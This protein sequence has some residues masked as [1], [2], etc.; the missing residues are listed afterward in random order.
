[1]AYQHQLKVHNNLTKQLEP[2]VPI[3]PQQVRMYVC[4][5][6]VYDYCHIGHARVLVVFDIISRYLRHIYGAGKVTYVRNITDIDDKII[7]RANDNGEDF[8]V[9]TGRFIEAMH[10]DADA[11]GVAPPDQEPRA[12]LFMAEIIAMIGQLIANG[13]AYAAAN[14]DV[15]Y[16]VSKFDGYGRLSGKNP[17]DLRAG[18]RV[19]VDEAKDDP[20]DFVL[21]KAA[22]PDEPSWDSPWG[23]GRPGWHIEC[24]VMST[25]ALGEHFDIHGGGLDLQFPHHE[26]EI[27]QSEGACG[28]KFVNYWLHNGFV[29]VDNEKMSK[30]LGNFFTIREVM[31]K[32]D[33]EVIRYFILS[34]HYRSPLNYSDQHLDNAKAALTSLYNALRGIEADAPAMD[35]SDYARRFYAAM[36]DDFGTPEALAV[37]FELSHEINRLRSTDAAAAAHHA[38]LLVRLAG[39]LGL[40]QREPEQFLRGASRGDGPTDEEIERLIAERI[41]A[42]SN[43]DFA[44]SDRI[45]DELKAQGIVLEDGPQGTTWRRD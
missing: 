23:R 8:N 22:K 20:L 5:M 31:A 38:A 18:E 7:Q 39:M 12:T 26:N 4:G 34:S 40:L 37:L 1:M 35:E 3:D 32:Y 17:E 6:T 2:F 25:H 21:W 42:R 16:D 41:A 10:E 29:R 36:D 15:Y 9:L 45:R 19:A 24:S 44:T 13:Y 33:P 14:G 11:L 30:S 43:K 28:C 27:A